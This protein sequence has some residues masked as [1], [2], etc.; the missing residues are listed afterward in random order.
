MERPLFRFNVLYNGTVICEPCP[1]W[2]PPRPHAKRWLGQSFQLDFVPPPVRGHAQPGLPKQT[3]QLWR[4]DFGHGIQGWR[5]DKQTPVL[6]TEYRL[7]EGLTVRQEIFAHIKG[8]KDVQ[9]GIEPI[10][11]WIRLSVIHVDELSAPDTIDF[12]VQLSKV[13]YEHDGRYVYEDGVAVDVDPKKAP[14]P[15]TLR[16]ENSG[17]GDKAVMSNLEPDGKVRMLISSTSGEG[18]SFMEATEGV[19]ALNVK[20]AAKTGTHVDML[21]PMLPDKSEDIDPEFSLGFDN[22]LAQCE[23]YW[24]KSRPPR[25]PFRCR[26][27]ISIVPSSR[28]S[29]SRRSLRKKIMSMGNTRF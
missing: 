16:A 4:L 6:W 1:H 11:A 23:P 25:Q 22:A 18:I 21:V 29:S 13:Y 15:K 26:K 10:Y 19:Y 17:A 5:T 24:Q 2:T 7:Q 3:T 27:N 14:Y 9:S 28:A 12:H 8:S 20:L